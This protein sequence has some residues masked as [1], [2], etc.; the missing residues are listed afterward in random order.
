MSMAIGRYVRLTPKFARCLRRRWWISRRSN[1]P[2]MRPNRCLQSEGW[3]CSNGSPTQQ[4]PSMVLT[5]LLLGRT[6]DFH[7]HTAGKSAVIQAGRFIPCTSCHCPSLGKGCRHPYGARHS[8][9][10]FPCTV[11]TA[12]AGSS[13]AWRACTSIAAHAHHPCRGVRA[14][15]TVTVLLCGLVS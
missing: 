6:G 11:P 10:G 4:Q 9:H 12:R 5:G 15:L 7:N 3:P 1:T 8:T 13:R 2:V 14:S